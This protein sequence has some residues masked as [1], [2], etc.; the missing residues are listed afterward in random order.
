ML[1]KRLLFLLFPFCGLAQN[2]QP[3]WQNAEVLVRNGDTRRTE[4]VFHADREQALTLPFEQSRNYYSLNG[5]WRFRYFSS[6]EEVP[7]NIEST[8][9]SQTDTW[10]TIKVP[11]NW[12]VQGFGTPIYVNLVYEFAPVDPQPPQLPTKNPVGIYYRS[13]R[14]PDGWSGR[15]V[16][17]NICGAKSGV[18]L[19]VNNRE[20]GYCEDSKSLV[21]YDVTPY[22]REGENDLMLRISRWSTG[23]YLE[24]QDFWRLSGIERDVYLSSERTKSNFDF[25]VV[26]TLDDRCRKGLFELRVTTAPDRKIDCSYELL[27]RSGKIV[28]SGAKSVVGSAS[29]KGEV[30]AVRQWSA[31]HPELYTLLLCVDGEYSRFNV[32]FRRF[33]IVDHPQK[34][35]NGRNYRVLLVNGQPVKFKGVNLHEH[36]PYTGHYVSRERMLQDLTLMRANNINAIRT[37]HYPQPRYF[38]ELCDSLGFYVYSEANIESHGMGYKLPRTLGNNRAWYPAHIDRILNMYMRT[39]NYPCVTILSLGNE[40]GNGYNFYRAYEE[41]ERCEKAGMNR[42]ICYERAVFEWNTDMLVPQYPSADWFRRM[43]EEGSDRPVC[44]SEYAHAMGNSTGSLDLQWKYIYA[45]PN[46]QGGF[47]WDWVDQGLAAKAADGSFYWAYGGDYGQQMPSDANFCCNGLV[48]PDRQPHPALAE[49][50][51]VYQNV[52]IEADN[53]KLGKFRVNNRFYFT[54]LKGYEVR[55]RIHADGQLLRRGALRFATA[56]QQKEAFAIALPRLAADKRCW[57]DFDVVT[58]QS[59]PLLPVGS[60]VATEQFLLQEPALPHYALKGGTTPEVEQNDRAIML[61]A[62]QAELV[63]DR[64]KGYVTSYKIQGRELLSDG[65]GLRPNFWRAPNDNDYG[66]GQPKRAQVWKTAGRAFAATARLQE[67]ED[68]TALIVAYAL[69][70]GGCFEVS[71]TLLSNG[72]LIVDADFRGA[73]SEQP[74]DLPRVG[75]RMRLPA[76]ADRFT[77]FGRGPEENYC[78]RNSGARM[79]RY[80]TSATAEYFPYVRPQECGHHTDCAWIEIGG[81][82]LVAADR[83]EF[84][85]LRNSVEDFDSEEAVAHDYQWSNFSPD[86]DHS[87]AAGRN[88][89]RRQHH[90]NDIKP[91]DFVELCID[92]RQ[93]GVGGYDSWGARPEHARTLWSNGRYRLR[94]AIVP[95]KI[96][97]AEKAVRYSY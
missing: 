69:P 86:E 11:A 15:R 58:L 34:D 68:R 29:W 57:I 8:T 52:A 95:Q 4:M 55:Y 61:R 12:E 40:A 71:Y 43:G 48:N 47:I 62:Q 94:F 89:L 25:E 27:D 31:E 16:F 72:I 97:S 49:V 45:Y 9:A 60:V 14:L 88:I 32:G 24:C 44:P 38:Y 75:L 37:A 30:E 22:L 79:G 7:T 67:K 77:Y 3:Y 80:A 20:V 54:D 78:D 23:S 53:A 18:C 59:R 65:F 46:L 87:P 63:F 36:D 28:L 73:A 39:R 70:D 1:M 92:Y 26:S 85:A 51:Y 19:Y 6:Q 74:T 21:R 76:S 42:P 91:R 90:I 81:V 50:K 93:S 84:N 5:A 66:N 33:E 83:F 41:L 2:A 56:P 82:T 10:E 96:M 64:T 13:F 35:K 17:L